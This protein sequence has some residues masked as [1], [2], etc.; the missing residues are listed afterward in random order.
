M[1]F[2]LGAFDIVSYRRVFAVFVVCTVVL[3]A[4]FVWPT[5]EFATSWW[6]RMVL[7]FPIVY[8]VADTL[9]LT[10]WVVVAN[11]LS[12]AIMLTLPF[13]A[14]VIARMIGS[15]VLSLTRREQVATIAVVVAVGVMGFYIGTENDRF[16]TCRDFERMGEF[17]PTGCTR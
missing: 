8:V 6:S 17:V 4:T 1:G 16:L 13:A 12:A 14:W 7:A 15:D 2:E 3:V 9:W 5:A 11:G 10:E